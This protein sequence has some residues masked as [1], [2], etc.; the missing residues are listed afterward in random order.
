M[1]EF[2]NYR[3][4]TI[5]VNKDFFDGVDTTDLEGVKFNVSKVSVPGN[6]PQ[7]G[8]MTTDVAGMAT[9]S[10]KPGTY[11]LTEMPDL[12]GDGISDFAQGLMINSAVF[13][14]P[15]GDPFGVVPGGTYGEMWEITVTSGQNPI[16]T[17]VNTIKGSIHGHKFKDFAAIGN[18]NGQL[19]PGE[20]GLQDVKF[21]IQ[22]FVKSTILANT[23]S[24]VVEIWERLHQARS[25]LD[26]IQRQER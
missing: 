2:L 26:D 3:N 14:H 19:D 11:K 18:P 21:T 24:T 8:D 16:A 25:R 5:K 22:Y 1:V 12:N 9:W 23:G 13:K 4:A 17:I 7:P 20:G 10:V 15:N 6:P